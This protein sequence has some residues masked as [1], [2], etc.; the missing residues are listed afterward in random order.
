LSGSSVT[1]AIRFT[2]SIGDLPA[3][4]IDPQLAVNGLATGHG[5]RIVV[6]NLEGDVHPGGHRG[7]DSQTARVEV[8]AIT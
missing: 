8:G 3:E 4:L 7:A 1:S 2:P 5:H 6:E